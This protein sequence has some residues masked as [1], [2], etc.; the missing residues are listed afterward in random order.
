MVTLVNHM[1]DVSVTVIEPRY[2]WERVVSEGS[3][4]LNKSKRCMRTET[5]VFI[6]FECNRMRLLQSCSHL[7]FKL[8]VHDIRVVMIRDKFTHLK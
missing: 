5:A 7:H 3:F 4:S 8:I 2:F 1:T 6:Y